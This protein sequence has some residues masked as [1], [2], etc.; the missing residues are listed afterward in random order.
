MSVKVAKPGELKTQYNYE[1]ESFFKYPLQKVY[2]I[3][4]NNRKENVY[5]FRRLGYRV[6]P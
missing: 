5:N 3:A 6:K 1:L 2:Y 4:I